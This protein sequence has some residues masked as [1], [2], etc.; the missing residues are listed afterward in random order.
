MLRPGR[1]FAIAHRM[2]SA[3][4]R[5]TAH[6][7]TVFLPKPLHKIDEPPAH[8][9]IKIGN[10]AFFYRLDERLALLV[11]QQRLTALGLSTLQAIW[12]VPV[13]ALDPIADDLQTDPANRGGM[14]PRTAFVNH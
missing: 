8:H 13:E 3:P 11:V 14:A 6:R 7:D 12:T 10:G 9:A 2:Q 4:K 5:L 1:E